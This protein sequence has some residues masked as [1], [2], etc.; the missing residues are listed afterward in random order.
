MTNSKNNPKTETVFITGASSGLGQQMA[1][2]FARRGYQLALTARRLEN[3]EQLK[4]KL[5]A[6]YQTAVLIRALDVTEFDDVKAALEEARQHFGSL[7]KIIANAGIGYSQRIG[8]L[9]FEKVKA[10]IDTN[11]LGCMATIDAAVSLFKAQGFGHIIAVSS[12]AGYRGLPGGGAYGASKAAVSHYVEA[13]RAE[14]YFKP[15]DVTLL[16]PGY[17]DTPINQAARSRPFCIPVEKGGRLLVDL[18]ERKVKRSTV[19]R[20]P[21]ALVV[22]LLAWLPVALIARMA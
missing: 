4:A 19:P 14:L 2:E 11:V 7:D 5:E 15:I 1:I 20:W 9:S 13:L 8:K 16:C 21:W 3:L 18:I 10:T 6:E 22:R 12:V 17:I